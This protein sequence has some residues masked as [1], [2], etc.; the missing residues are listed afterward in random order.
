[1]E[2]SAAASLPFADRRAAGRALAAEI[3]RR[4]GEDPAFGAVLRSALVFALPRGGVPVGREIALL[5]GA[6]LDLVLVR[7]I[8]V[9]GNEEL[10]AGAV[11]NG[12]APEIVRNPDVIAQARIGEAEIAR[13]AEAGL[14]E[15]ARRRAAWL[16]G[17]PQPDPAG[18]AVIVTDDGIATGAT[19]LAA[20]RAL[21]RRR[22]SALILAVPV[23]PPDALARLAAEADVTVCLAAPADFGSVGRFYLDFGQ[24]SDEDV[25]ADLA[26]VQGPA[27][28]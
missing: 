17:R 6:P 16:G 5:L 15:I 19:A 2:R 20:L 3:A 28:G 23:A 8:G 7:K 11:V 4:A 18:R 22:P 14:A 9:P 1:V 27:G 25:L 26:A 21:R 10:A 12:S 13:R 24:L